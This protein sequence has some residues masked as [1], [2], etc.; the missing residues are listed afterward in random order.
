MPSHDAQGRAGRALPDALAGAAAR[1]ASC[2]RRA[3][4]GRGG[5]ASRRRPTRPL[6]RSD[7]P[8]GVAAA[9]GGRRRGRA[10]ARGGAIE[11]EPRTARARDEQRAERPETMRRASRCYATRKR[12][13]PRSPR[14]VRAVPTNAQL[15]IDRA[16]DLF[17]APS[18]PARWPAS[19]ARSGRR[20]RARHLGGLG[21]RGAA[22]PWRGS[23]PGTSSTSTS[24][25][26]ASPFGRAQGQELRELRDEAR[27]NSR[28]TRL[29]RLEAGRPRSGARPS[30]RL[31]TESG[32]EE[33]VR[34]AYSVRSGPRCSGPA[35]RSCPGEW[36]T[37]DDLLRDT[38]GAR[39][40]ALREAHRVLQER[41]Q[42]RGDRRPAQV[43]AAR[44][45]RDR[46]RQ[47]RAPR[48][49]PPA[50]GHVPQHR[51]LRPEPQRVDVLHVDGGARGNPGPAGVGVVVAD[52][53]GNELDRA[54]DYIG[55][56]TNNVAEYRALLLGLERARE[57]GRTRGRGR[58]RLPARGAAGDRRVPGQEGR[59][60]GSCTRR[61]CRR[62]A[63]SSAGRSARCR[64]SR[65]SSPTSS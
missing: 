32:G 31:P 17:N 16:L 38:P 52:E 61:P 55:E 12:S 44:A 29:E 53:H 28:R 42:R 20:M 9:R 22:R 33:P 35:G 6:S 40:R 41:P 30:R 62:C 43:R 34:G 63:S 60:C 5:S 51:P 27:W 25:T 58:E 10:V 59:T 1:C 65:T 64:G 50:P 46:R 2:A 21:R 24:R 14:H 49:A 13:R 19:P 26:R 47:A 23:C 54:N 48:P 18:I 7:S 8:S 57:L 15:K 11:P 4:S 39:R 36:R 3:P 37:V 56:A 45:R